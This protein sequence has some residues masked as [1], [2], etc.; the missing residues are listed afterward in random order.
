MKSLLILLIVMAV[1][2]VIFFLTTYVCFFI[3]FYVKRKK[4][5]EN[6]DFKLPPGKI[7]LPFKDKMFKWMKETREMSHTEYKITSFDGLTLYGKYYEYQ[8]GAPLEIMFP[9]YRGLAERDLCGAVQRCFVLKRNALV[10]DQRTCGKSEGKVI[11]FG[12]REHRDCLDWIDFAVKEFGNDVKIFITG[13]SM[14]AST[15]IMA[16]GKELPDNVVGV[17]A[18]CG[19]SSAREIICKVIKQLHL[20]SGIL[21]PFVKWGAKIYGGFDLEEYSPNDA[22]E[23]IRIPVIFIHGED[24]DFVPCYMSE[25]MYKACNAKKTIFTVKGAGHGLSYLIDT[26]GYYKTLQ[27]FE[28]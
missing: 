25:K 4:Y 11:T 22:V 21:Y 15:V 28:E 9:G 27:E 16:A 5:D 7:Y 13:I 19:F 6:E 26:D 17:L 1:L 14:G 12:V 10:V 23:K 2:A 20:P 3:T 8:K 24:D 18:D